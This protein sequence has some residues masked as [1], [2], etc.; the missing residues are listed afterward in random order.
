M[1]RRTKDINIIVKKIYPILEKNM[2]PTNVRNY[3]KLVGQFIEKRQESLYDI[4]PCDR[5]IFTQNDRDDVYR[6]LRI[7]EKDIAYIL[8]DTYYWDIP[9][10]NPVAARDE[11]TILMM[12]IIR[13]FFLKKDTK[14]LELSLIHFS[15]SG[16]F[17]P[18]IHH[19]SYPVVQP[20]EYRHIMEYVVN[21]E[22]SNKYDIKREGSVIGA[23]KSVALTWINS[24]EDMFKTFDDED[25]AYLIQQLHTRIKS[26]TKNIAEIYYK[27]YDNKDKYMTYDSDNLSETDYR[28]AD[29][30]S[31]KVE[32]YLESAM[33]NL[34]SKG[35]DPTIVRIAANNN[36]KIEELR[37]ILETIMD[38]NDNIPVVK[39]LIRI[40]LVEYFVNSKDKDPSNIRFISTSIASKPNTKNPNIHRQN[41][42]LEGWLDENSP[43][44][45][46]RKSRLATK[47]AYHKAVLS[48]F[49]LVTHK[50]AK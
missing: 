15:F 27:V 42:I 32:R 19:G 25:V 38:G 4:A 21:N 17:Y 2:T 30:D 43:N 35:I 50:S 8:K 46:R 1:S 33:S 41:E 37:S 49:V 5:I 7:P 6:L 24:Y 14:N 34:L 22:L 12:C 23:I 40:L 36:I 11:L 9:R 47:L 31:F 16:K 10:F 26:F 18:S 28:L 45:R 39:E 3:I 44:Y 29:N 20:S 48:Y 13:Y